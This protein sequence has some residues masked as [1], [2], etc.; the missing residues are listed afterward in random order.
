M[1]CHL[2]LPACLL[3]VDAACSLPACSL[4]RRVVVCGKA[5]A[6]GSV[7]SWLIQLLFPSSIA[8]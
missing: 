6:T 1:R 8:L 4:M 2:H 3:H 7:L 5:T